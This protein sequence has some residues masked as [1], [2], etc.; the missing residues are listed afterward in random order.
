[1]SVRACL[2]WGII[3]LIGGWL[4]SACGGAKSALSQLEKQKYPKA[5]ELLSKALTKDSLPVDAYYVYSLLYTDSSFSGYDIDTAY[6]YAQQAISGYSQLDEKRRSRVYQQ[7]AL[8]TARLRKQKLHIDS[9]AYARANEDSSMRAYQR[10]ITNFATAPQ[11]PQAVRRR[12]QL[13]YDSVQRIDTYSAYKYFMDTYPAAEQYASARQRYNTLTFQ[14]LTQAGDLSSYLKFLQDYPSSPYR[15]QAEQAIFEISTADNR[16]ESYAAF[17]RQYPR[18]APSRQAINILYHL[19]KSSYSPT[20]FLQDFP[21]LPYADSL[22]Q[23]IR[24][25]NQVLAPVLDGDRYGFIDN[26]GNTVIDS[27]YD[28]LPSSYF[29]EG[30]LLDFVHTGVVDGNQLRHHVLT[31]AGAPVISLTTAYD[32]SDVYLEEVVEDMGAGLLEVTTGDQRTVWHKAGYPVLPAFEQATEVSLMPSDDQAHGVW[33]VPYQFIKFRVEDQWGIKAFSGRTLLEPAYESID[34]YGPFLVLERDG[35]LAVTNRQTLLEHIG[36]P[37]PTDFLYDDIALL[38][39]QFLL[40]YQDDQE[41]VL[42]AQLNTVVPLGDYRIVHRVSSDSLASGR[43]LVK[44]TEAVQRVLGD[45]L[46][47]ENQTSYYLYPPKNPARGIVSFR[48][49]FYN[50]EWLALKGNRKFS[51]INYQRTDNNRIA[52]DSIQILG[53]H[54]VLTFQALGTGQ[55]SVTVL[56]DKGRQRTFAL[57]RGNDGKANPGFRLLRTEGVVTPNQLREYLLIDPLYDPQM[58]MNPQGEVIVEQPLSD[59]TV[60]PSGLLVI[61][62]GRYQGLIDSTGQELL[63]PRYDGIGNYAA[64]GTL[65][66]FKGKR[67]GLYQHP[68]GTIIEPTYESALTLYSRLDSAAQSLFVAKENGKYGIVTATNQSATPFAFERVVYW[69]DTSALVKADG[70]WMIYRLSDQI[71][72]KRELNE[73]DVLYEGIDD[74]SFFS[75]GGNQQEQLLR[76]YASKSYGVLSSQRGELLSP[77]YDGISLFGAATADDYLFFTE[78]YVPEAE[79]YIMIYLDADGRLVKRLALTPD[80]YD[81]MYCQ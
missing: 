70:Q 36:K 30:V 57:Q 32:S 21:G 56:L 64:P 75:E 52:Y 50:D 66:L 67:F 49:A 38:E 18:S 62:A 24:T 13:A 19:Y 3:L 40:A 76:I 14:E 59:A 12:D 61:Q 53:E 6:Q 17:A 4:M 1:M 74:F 79:L 27:R 81:R 60:Y 48:K 28:Y 80:Q 2:L 42:D 8:D 51:L 5:Q 45:S 68:A 71:A 23:A 33:S 16:L 54:F 25:E 47:A 65:S 34:E 73:E 72:N 69:N 63:P 26:Q 20:T 29:C 37:L 78:K 10:F 77:T 58:L 43:W 15:P 39:G 11:V 22:R 46:V 44:R 31:K 35:L 7:L 41:T 55:D 9:L